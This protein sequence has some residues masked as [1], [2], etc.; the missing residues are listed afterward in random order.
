MIFILI[1]G[2]LGIVLGYVIL[3]MVLLTEIGYISININSA[4]LGV[5]VLMA[6][7]IISLKGYI[8]K[9]SN[10]AIVDELNR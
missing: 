1:G 8:K 9:I 10:T 2:I 4:L 3:N 7:S 6:V 5:L